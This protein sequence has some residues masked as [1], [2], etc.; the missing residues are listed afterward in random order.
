MLQRDVGFFQ[1]RTE[2]FLRPAYLHAVTDEGKRFL[3]I[4]DKVCGSL[5]R[6]VANLRIRIVR[7]HAISLARHPFR[8]ADLR[9]AREV[10]HH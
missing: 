2:L 9:I 1:E 5:H 7:A 10:E 6:L 4:I 8:L 3:G